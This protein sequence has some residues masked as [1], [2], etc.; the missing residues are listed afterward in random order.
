M[1]KYV[2]QMWRIHDVLFLDKEEAEDGKEIVKQVLVGIDED[3][4]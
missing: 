3:T 4:E 2:Q 1:R